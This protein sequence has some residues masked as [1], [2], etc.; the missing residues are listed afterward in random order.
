MQWLNESL[1]CLFKAKCLFAIIYT[2]W[3]SN[4]YEPY[5]LTPKLST[6]NRYFMYT[7]HRE[8]SW[9]SKHRVKINLFGTAEPLHAPM[10]S[11]LPYQ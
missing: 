2:S 5:Q 3:F 4:E 1:F 9:I 6:E 10:N 8:I 7:D 11:N